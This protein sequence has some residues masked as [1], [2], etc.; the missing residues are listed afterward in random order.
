MTREPFGEI[1]DEA[2][3]KLARYKQGARFTSRWIVP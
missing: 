3:P 2:G 1:C